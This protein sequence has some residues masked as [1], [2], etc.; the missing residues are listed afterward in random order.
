MNVFDG[1]SYNGD[2]LIQVIDNK[3]TFTARTNSPVVCH[4]LVEIYTTLNIHSVLRTLGQEVVDIYH[5]PATHFYH[6]HFLSLTFYQHL[7]YSKNARLFLS[8]YKMYTFL[9]FYHICV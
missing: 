2:D 8:S 6:S 1:Y 4:W 3:N 7:Y 9:S 5:F